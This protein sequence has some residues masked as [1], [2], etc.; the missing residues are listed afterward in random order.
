MRQ[1]LIFSLLITAMTAWGQTRPATVKESKRIFTTYGFSDPNP[2][3]EMGKVYQYYRFDGYTN[4]PT[5]KEWKVVELE[6]DVIRVW[7]LPEIGGKIWGA[8]EKVTGNPF[9][10][11]IQ[12]VKFR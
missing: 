2:I 4:T 11:S 10:Y 8:Y 5:K 9:I 3:P 12:V 1:L 6:N 7:V